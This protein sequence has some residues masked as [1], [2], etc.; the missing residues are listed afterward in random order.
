[1]DVRFV[2]AKVDL[3][4]AESVAS[5]LA[6]GF[7]VHE[8]EAFGA[9]F[10]DLGSQ[11]IAAEELFRGAGSACS[12]DVRVLMRRALLLSATS[13]ILW[14]SHPSGT[15]EPSLHDIELS[16]RVARAGEQLEVR[17]IDH[18]IVAPDGSFTSMRRKRC[19]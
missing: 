15:T 16:K 7:R 3:K 1:M 9:L 11:L 2:A 5:F 10:F 12:V 17:L 19:W 14:H 18:L 13:L 4:D 8:Q 6:Q